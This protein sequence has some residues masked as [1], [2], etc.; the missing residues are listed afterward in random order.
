MKETMN[1]VYSGDDGYQDA[2][3]ISALSLCKHN[4]DRPIHLYFL[5]GDFPEINSSFISLKEGSARRIGSY[6][7]KYNPHVSYDIIDCTKIYNQYLSHNANK[8]SRYSVYAMLRLFLDQLSGIPD[9]ILYLDG[10]TVVMKPID[11]LYD[12]ELGDH[13]IGMVQDAVGH[14][15][16]GRHYCNS[17]VLLADI[18][19]LRKDRNFEKAL[20]YMAHH[21][22]FMPDQTSINRT[23]KNSIL[24]LD[25]KYNEQKATD[26]ETVIRHYCKVFHL[27]PYIHVSD[28]KPWRCDEFEK[29]FKDENR[30]IAEEY[31]KIKAEE[32]K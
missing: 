20:D 30:D 4:P 7:Q 8:K 13:D 17:G 15:Y 5:T 6:C 26:E 12:T 23:M 28:Y 1:I 14:K 27:F 31:R 29:K 2:L 21:H 3:L 32:K 22:L 19:R 16:F 9:R 10:D 24:M 18:A 25:K 11:E